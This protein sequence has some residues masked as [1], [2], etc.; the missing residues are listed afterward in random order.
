MCLLP[1]RPSIRALVGRG[2]S[3]SVL[4][5]AGSWAITTRGSNR[6][7]GRSDDFIPRADLPFG[8]LSGGHHPL[9]GASQPVRCLACWA[10]LSIWSTLACVGVHPPSFRRILEYHGTTGTNLSLASHLYGN[11]T[12][13]QVNIC[14]LLDLGVVLKKGTPCPCLPRAPTRKRTSGQ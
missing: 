7:S 14:R 6:C 13:Q 3:C 2:T 12:K 10:D 8:T 1:T 9:R 11:P 5:L 4:Y